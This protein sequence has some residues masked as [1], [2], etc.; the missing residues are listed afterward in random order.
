M[1]VMEKIQNSKTWC[2]LYELI[3]NV[4]FYVLKNKCIY[5][6]FIFYILHVMC[7]LYINIINITYL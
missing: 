5:E 1:K 2:S 3:Q 6:Y 4:Q 7:I